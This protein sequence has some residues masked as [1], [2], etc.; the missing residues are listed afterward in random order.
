MFWMVQSVEQNQNFFWR[1]THATVVRLLPDRCIWSSV[2]LHKL[3][4][5]CNQEVLAFWKNWAICN[6]REYIEVDPACGVNLPQTNLSKWPLVNTR[7][8]KNHLRKR[9]FS[10]AP[11]SGWSLRFLRDVARAIGNERIL[12]VS[13]GSRLGFQKPGT[14]QRIIFTHRAD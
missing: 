1:N 14:P 3:K 11:G 5:T 4:I 12:R 7:R 9:L 13:A 6:L 10:S 2:F 8:L